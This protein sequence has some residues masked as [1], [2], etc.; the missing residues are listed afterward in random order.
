[1]SS[2]FRRPTP[3]PPR[4]FC[5]PSRPGRKS[6]KP[7]GPDAAP[8]PCGPAPT[9]AAQARP[10]T[11]APF[12]KRQRRDREGRVARIRSSPG[13]HRPPLPWP[14]RA[15]RCPWDRQT[16]LVRPWLRRSTGDQA[17]SAHAGCC[18]AVPPAPSSST[19]V[20]RSSPFSPTRCSPIPCSPTRPTAPLSRPRHPSGR[21]GE[22]Q[23]TAD[24]TARHL[25]DPFLVTAARTLWTTRARAPCPRPHWT[26]PLELD[27]SLPPRDDESALLS[28]TRRGT[29][30]ATC[31]PPG[32][33]RS[34]ALLAE[35]CSLGSRPHQCPAQDRR[36]HRRCLP[37]QTRYSPSLFL[38]RL[39]TRHPRSSL[40]RTRLGLMSRP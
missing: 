10:Q 6:R 15:G 21:D 26:G 31:P 9:Y 16:S 20:H 3:T 4:C 24:G 30:R 34:A 8:L 35:R 5:L 33:F 27:V 14:C 36:A 11:P 38:G 29:T 17:R 18:P 39:T 2:E 23:V 13:S 25:P 1:M 12:S 28:A 37:D 32:P 40:H 19:S 22:R 7:S